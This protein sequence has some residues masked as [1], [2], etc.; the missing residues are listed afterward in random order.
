MYTFYVSE[1]IYICI[2]FIIS[3]ALE[4]LSLVVSELLSVVGEVVMLVG[5]SERPVS[6]NNTQQTQRILNSQ[7]LT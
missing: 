7:R 3:M 1:F 2:H 5:S 4:M 6:T